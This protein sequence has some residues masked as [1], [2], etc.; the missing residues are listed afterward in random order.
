LDWAQSGAMHLTGL[1]DAPPLAAPAAIAS[2]MRGAAQALS[3][4]SS[5]L[6]G[7]TLADLDGPALLGERAA[8][9]QPKPL[10]RRG[11]IAPGGSCRLLAC[12][13]GWLALNLTR[14]DDSRLLAAWLETEVSGD[15]WQAVSAAVATRSRDA[16]VD[17]AR[18][19]GL[20]AAPLE[21]AGNPA[22]ARWCREAVRG[23][24]RTP[25]GRVPLVVDLSSLWAGPLCGQLLVASGAR[26]LKLESFQRPDGA[27][28]GPPAFFDRINGGKQSLAV[29]IDSDTGLQRLRALV[30]RADI[31][32]ESN[33]P[34][35]LDQLGIEPAEIV[36]SRPG[37]TWL[38]ITGYGL[39]APESGWVAFGDDAAAAAG[40]TATADGGTPVF[41]GDAIADPITGLHAAV[42]AL[43]SWLTGGGKLL[44][45]SLRNVAAKVAT[46]TAEN[47]GRAIAKPLPP[48]ARP[49]LQAAAPLGRD[50]DRVLSELGIR[51]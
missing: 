43:A 25:S 19:M 11:P 3:L 49:F 6:P 44:D 46:L 24:T 45:V 4:L 47:P 8:L 29:D 48:R 26:V 28:G 18:L 34:R 22:G 35:A 36:R 31:V 10:E 32:I 15:G 20:P 14:P 50:T 21:A 13:D 16:L 51:C 37:Q 42:A 39:D 30:E 17:R 38:S 12:A 2:C 27:R 41:C 1:P 5:A 40:L 33:R 23:S 9:A 7:D